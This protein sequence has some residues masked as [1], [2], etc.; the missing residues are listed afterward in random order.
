MAV[1]A[2]TTIRWMRFRKCGEFLCL[3][4]ALKIKGRLYQICV[5]SA[6]L[7][8]SET[9]CFREKKRGTDKKNQKSYDDR[10]EWN[11]AD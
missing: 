10:Y 9:W 3:R 2:R 5:R 7:Y 4:F 6:I 1:V 11:N 8:Q